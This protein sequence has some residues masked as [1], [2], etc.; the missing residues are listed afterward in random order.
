MKSHKSSQSLRL[1]TNIVSQCMLCCLILVTSGCD[2]KVG[3]QAQNN[4]S[5]SVGGVKYL[6]PWE[7]SNHQ[8]MPG[9]F[10]YTGDSVSFTDA[11]GALVVSGKS[12]G[13]V[14]AGDTVDLTKTGKVIVNGTERSAQ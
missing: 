6:V 8:E 5:Y 3:V 10:T 7:T 13:A 14:K 4:R 12:Y 11:G 1:F 9:R 2:V